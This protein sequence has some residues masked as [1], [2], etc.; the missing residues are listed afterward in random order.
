MEPVSMLAAGASLNPRKNNAGFS[1]EQ[2]TRL[3]DS[4]SSEP[5]AAKRKQ[6][7]SQIN[8]YILDQSFGIP[9]APSTSRVVTKANVQGLEFGYNDIM[10]LVNTWKG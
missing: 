6:I 3:V 2:Y 8:D 4:A 9:M 10:R 1:D 7:Y 5:D